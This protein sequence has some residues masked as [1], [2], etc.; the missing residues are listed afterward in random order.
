MMRNHVLPLTR[1]S[2]VSLLRRGVWDKGPI[3]ITIVNTCSGVKTTNPE[4]KEYSTR[5]NRVRLENLDTKDMQVFKVRFAGSN[6]RLSS[7]LKS[8]SLWSGFISSFNNLTCLSRFS[9]LT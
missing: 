1:F 9:I 2:E 6:K 8:E 3:S 5:L 7:L 4:Y